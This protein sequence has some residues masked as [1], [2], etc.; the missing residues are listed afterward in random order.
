MDAAA[1]VVDASVWVSWFI[2]RDVNNSTCTPI[3]H[4]SRKLGQRATAKS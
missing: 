1:V 2:E 4:S 3:Q